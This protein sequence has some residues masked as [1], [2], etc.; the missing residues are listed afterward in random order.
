M[1]TKKNI[2]NISIISVLLIIAFVV[3]TSSADAASLPYSTGKINSFGGATLRSSYSTTSKKVTVIPNNKKITIQ[4]E[5]FTSK[6]KNTKSSRWYYVKYGSKK[7]YVRSDLV[8]TI[9]YANSAAYTTDDLNYR[10]GVG[11]QMSV[12]GVLRSGTPLTI[13]L[14]ARYRNSSEVWYRVKIGNNSYYM[15]GKYLK[16]GKIATTKPSS[17]K[18][19]V[20]NA[21]LRNP[22]AGGTGCRIVY[23]FDEKNCSRKFEVSGIGAAYTPQGMAHNNSIYTFVFGNSGK[24]AIIR[25]NSS[26]KKLSSTYFSFNMGHPNGITYNPQTELYYIFKG[27]QKKAYTYDAKTGTFGSV[28]T[29]YSS[30]GIGYDASRGTMLASSRTGIREYSGDGNFEHM[31]L[32][33]KC[34]HSGTHY[35]QDCCAYRGIVLHGVSGSNKQ[36][37]NYIDVYRL[38]DNAYLGSINLK[39]GEIESMIVNGSGKLELLV[40]TPV[41]DYVWT[42]P[43]DVDQLA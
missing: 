5:I 12:K 13:Q 31:R 33:Y 40:N 26:G 21:L 3:I 39:V 14:R 17:D 9:K 4:R 7:G 36:T 34:T 2:Y 23:T 42:T 37:I 25:Y 8:D 22:T 20:A 32:I 28:N 43:L 1:T 10:S 16:L 19:D 27:N 38:A 29:P 6:T 41:K 15:I 18:S 35:V 30:S 24:Q 11:T